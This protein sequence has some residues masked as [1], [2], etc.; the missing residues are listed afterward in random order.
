MLIEV[1]ITPKIFMK[2][3]PDLVASQGEAP[4]EGHLRHGGLPGQAVGKTEGSEGEGEGNRP[5]G[6]G[7]RRQAD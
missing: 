2:F 3:T 6:W 4:Q 5:E 1:K 7:T